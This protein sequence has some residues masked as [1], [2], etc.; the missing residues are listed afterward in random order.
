MRKTKHILGSYLS[1][2]TE[3][4]WWFGDCKAI[5]EIVG[6]EEAIEDLKNR[7]KIIT[8]IKFYRALFLRWLFGGYK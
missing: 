6:G 5:V 2:F 1:T 4:A 8:K 3:V 7:S